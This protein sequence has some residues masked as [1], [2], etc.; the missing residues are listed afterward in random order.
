[1]WCTPPSVHMRGRIARRCAATLLAIPVALWTLAYLCGPAEPQIRHAA[2]LASAC[3]MGLLAVSMTWPLVR[4]A[5]SSSQRGRRDLL[6]EF[7]WQ[8][9]VLSSFFNLVWQVPL[10]LFRGTI[11]EAPK[12]RGNLFLFIAWWG[13]GFADSHYGTVTQWMKSEELMWF[14]AIVVGAVGMV[15]N[16]SG[17]KKGKSDK[18]TQKQAIGYTLMGI[19][20]ICESYNATLYV[21]YDCL[22]GFQN[23]VEKDWLSLALYW[24]FNPLWA[25]CSLAGG[26]ICLYEVLHCNDWGRNTT[27]K[28]ST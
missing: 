12:T 10:V 5:F 3:A 11:V 21:V 22:T 1:M 26:I 20:S 7:T 8:W 27:P 23:I 19:A 14:L 4:A 28:K 24:G 9:F 18:V 16:I 13:Y 17:T 2:K 15:L 25:G 6:R